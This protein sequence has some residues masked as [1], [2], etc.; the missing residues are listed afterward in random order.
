MTMAAREAGSC[1]KLRANPQMQPTGRPGPALRMSE[2]LL[3]AKQWKRLLV[4][5]GR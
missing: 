5:A 4:R 1:A 3:V 2:K